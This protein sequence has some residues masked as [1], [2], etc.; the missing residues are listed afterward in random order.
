[1]PSMFA[2]SRESSAAAVSKILRHLVDKGLI[3]A[4]VDLHDA[5]QRRY[6]LTQQGR[7]TMA[8]L[9]KNREK[10]IEAIWVPLSNQELDAFTRFGTRLTESMKNYT[11]GSAG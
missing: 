7:K 9:R 10:A 6:E 1:M 11:E 4:R 8:A 2:R 5:R 3:V